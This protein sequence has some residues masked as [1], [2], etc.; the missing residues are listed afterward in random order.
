MSDAAE[1]IETKNYWAVALEPVHVG[2]GG[3]RMGRV[4]LTVLRD[5]V[6]EVPKIPGTSISGAMK[7]FADLSLRDKEIK[8]PADKSCASTAGDGICKNRNTCP[9]CCAFGYTDGKKE[10]ESRQ[11]ILKFT[12]ATLFAFPVPTMKG[13]VW[14]T[15]KPI[16]HDILDITDGTDLTEE[17]IVIPNGS[18]VAPVNNMLNLG[19][20]YLEA[21]N[22]PSLNIGMLSGL[23]VGI[24]ASLVVLPTWL[25]SHVVNDNMEVRTSVSIDPTTGAA[26]D[27]ALFTYE[28]VPRG[29]I[30]A[31]SIVADDFAKLWPGVN[32]N[33]KTAITSP[34]TMIKDHAFPGIASVGL[35][36]MTTRGFGRMD[37]V[38][39]NGTAQ[40]T[41]TKTTE[42]VIHA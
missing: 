37:F 1:R 9:I 15:T 7:F 39:R 38:E 3:E 25:F 29:A 36:G 40:P 30:F 14:V 4:D 17:K 18:T 10:A 13:P 22:D 26:S 42:E 16:L 12:D 33:G 24:S 5:P 41:V 8:K 20:I 27:T 31:T 11:G 21:G 28:A 35:G 6:L 19:W 34:I 23:P 32:W 2:T